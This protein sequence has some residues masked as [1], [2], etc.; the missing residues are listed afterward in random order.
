MAFTLK[1]KYFNTFVLREQPKFGTTLVNART[2]TTTVEHTIGTAPVADLVIQGPGIKDALTI[3]SITDADTFESSTATTFEK[4]TVLSF[5]RADPWSGSERSTWHVEESRI[6]GKYS[7]KTIDLGAKAYM[8]DK[9]YDR[10]HRENALIYSGIFNKR[11]GVNN[12]NEFS[13]AESITKAVDIAHGSIQK[14]Y[15]EDTNLTIFQ[16]NK[17][18]RALVDKD[19][20]YTAEGGQLTI[21][22]AKVIGQITPYSGEYG[23]S[24]NPESFA[25]YGYQKYFTD[26]NKGVVLRLSRDGLTEISSYSMKGFFRD[27]LKDAREVYGMYDIHTKSYVVSL[28]S[29]VIVDHIN[30]TWEMTTDEEA[31]KTSNDIIITLKNNHHNFKAGQIIKVNDEYKDAHIVN[32]DGNKVQ[33]N[34]KLNITIND[35]ITAEAE[36]FSNNIS[37]PKEYYKTLSFDERVNGWTSFFTYAP[38]FGGSIT[39]NFYTW[40]KGNLYKHY[41]DTSTKNTFYGKFKP[42]VVKI[43]S[44]QNPS[45]VKHFKSINY[46]GTNGWKAISIKGPATDNIFNESYPVPGAIKGR[47]IKDGKVAF[48]GFEPLEKKYYARI[49]RRNDDDAFRGVDSLSSSGVSGFFTEITLEHEPLENNKDINQLL[50]AELFSVGLNYEQSLY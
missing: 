18:S 10:K 28:T 6:K 21:A 25:K 12:T 33:I 50:H 15:A 40:D 45:L 16:E 38:E 35:K 29:D 13:I 43:I 22:G 46:E 1:I 3:D 36:R 30:T 8:V 27:S 7:E 49:I 24:K 23:I 26:K 48:H 41:V 2:E 44:N 47:E 32:I 14:L 31:E 34:K 17:I 9:D 11:T 37:I 19:A 39:N 4:G 20:I 42:S 5:Y